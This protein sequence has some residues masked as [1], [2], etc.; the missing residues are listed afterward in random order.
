MPPKETPTA[1][2][3]RG[4][5]RRFF[6]RFFE[7]APRPLK[8]RRSRQLTPTGCSIWRRPCASKIGGRTVLENPFAF[9]PASLCGFA[10]PSPSRRSIPR[11][12]PI[13]THTLY[14]KT[15]RRQSSVGCLTCRLSNVKVSR[16]SSAHSPLQRIFE[17][18]PR[19]AIQHR[20][21]IIRLSAGAGKRK[22]VTVESPSHALAG[23]TPLQK[24]T[25]ARSP[26]SIGKNSVQPPR[27]ARSAHARNPTARA[28]SNR[29][30][31]TCE[32]GE[33]CGLGPK[34]PKPAAA[35]AFSALMR[36]ERRDSL[37]A[38]VSFFTTP[39][40]TAR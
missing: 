33:S 7:N 11:R 39:L 28:H 13:R 23:E 18:H 6:V 22:D 27:C 26:C 5:A 21:R 8:G 20:R 36:E 29:R 1:R 34:R 16:R 17:P 9:D 31:A 38:A 14:R 32:C 40:V 25:T 35:Q 19:A 30:A 12:A 2:D 3:A 15:L 4:P 10:P 37:R 24:N